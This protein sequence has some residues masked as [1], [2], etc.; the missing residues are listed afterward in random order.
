MIEKIKEMSDKE[1]VSFINRMSQNK[2]TLCIKCGNPTSRNNR[3]TINVGIYNRSV[4][5]KVKKL[6]TLCEDCYIELL[7]YLCVSDV[8]WSDNGN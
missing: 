6:C 4:G 3:K 7:D 1:L 5:Q 8:D 2:L